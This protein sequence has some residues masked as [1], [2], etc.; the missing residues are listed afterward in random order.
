MG[1]GSSTEQVPPQQREVEALAASTGALPMLQKAFSR[2][3]DPQIHSVPVISLQQCFSITFENT[4]CEASSMPDC[5]MGLFDHLG[6][7]IVD[8]FFVTE[9]GGISWIEFLRGYIKCC[10]RTTA[11]TSLNNLLRIFAA[12]A[13]KAGLPA[14]LQFESGDAD[15][16]VNGSLISVDI[17]MLLWMSWIMSWNSRKLKSSEGIADCGLPDISHLVLSAVV[18]CTEV[19]SELNVWDCDILCLD[20]QL[21]AG[22]IHVWALKTVP[23][24]AD[25]FTQFVHARLCSSLTSEDKLE[26]S[27]SSVSDISSTTGCNTYLL[28]RGRAWAISLTLKSPLSEGILKVCFP[29][30]GDRTN[31]SPLYRSSLHGKGLNRFWSNVEG[32]KGPMLTL[33]A[34]SSG[35]PDGNASIRRWIIGALTHQGYENRDVFYGS[36]GSIYAI[37]P[38]FHVF[39][40]SGKAKNFVYSH[41]HPAG[42]VYDPHPKP[43]GI[44]FGGSIGGERIFVDEDF[45]RLTIRHNAVDK[46]YQPGALFPDQGFLPVEA[47]VVEVEV[48]GLAGRAAMEVQ[49]SYKKREELFTEQRRKVDLKTF[50]NWDDSPEKMLMDMMSD[51]NRIQREDR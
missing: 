43:V 29:G 17:L 30:D 31:E 7:S 50:G 41:L 1:A 12:V 34:A 36:S 44:A 42:R 24:L 16:K 4:L 13:V 9:K 40:A 15:C 2:L 51:P 37:S 28:T 19:G 32:Y 14:K 21:P 26:P 33:I 35:D 11:S 38:V 23:S 48:W 27:C 45:A 8:L 22:K 18:S 47:L 46:T 20:V 3:V 49:N 6:P 5:F 10:W 39:S 25:C